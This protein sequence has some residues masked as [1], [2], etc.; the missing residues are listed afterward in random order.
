M[1]AEK[2]GKNGPSLPVPVEEEEEAAAAAAP[3]GGARGGRVQPLW[4]P[5]S[6]RRSGRAGAARKEPL[7]GGSGAR[8]PGIRVLRRGLDPGSGTAADRRPQAVFPLR[9]CAGRG[10]SLVLRPGRRHSA[11]VHRQREARTSPRKRPA[12]SPASPATTRASGRSSSSGRAR[13]S[14]ASRSRPESSCRSPSRS[15]T[16]SR[17][18]AATSAA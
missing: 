16:G 15:G 7:R 8:G 9:R 18:N 14:R 2:T 11:S 5:G 12:I 3:E 6:R 1:S 17:A 10:G 13:R 4:R